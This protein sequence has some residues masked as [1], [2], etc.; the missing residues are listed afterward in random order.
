MSENEIDH[1]YTQNI[2][3]PW[4]GSA[5]P[6]SWEVQAN[7][8]EETC[9]DCKNLFTYA[10]ETTVTYCTSKSGCAPGEKETA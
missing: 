8:G 1:R 2:V 7:E 6:D 5:N 10:R 3:C 4:C 9:P